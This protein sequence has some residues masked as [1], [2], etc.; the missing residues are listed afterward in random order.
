MK[1]EIT[2]ASAARPPL[3]CRTSPPLGGRSAVIGAFTTFQRRKKGGTVTLL[4]SPLVGEMAG[5]PE[6]G[7]VPPTSRQ[8]HPSNVRCLLVPPSLRQLLKR[9]VAAAKEIFICWATE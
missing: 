3:S 7:A 6:G 2:P 5:R 8:F 9:W 1:C 4:I